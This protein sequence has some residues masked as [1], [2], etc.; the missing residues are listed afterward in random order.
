MAGRE[1]S[2]VQISGPFKSWT[3]GHRM[4][5]DGANACTLEDRIE[6]ELPLG[7]LGNCLGGGLVGT[8]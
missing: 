7:A 4:T 6:Y 8:S 3:H 1:F 5:P 2:D